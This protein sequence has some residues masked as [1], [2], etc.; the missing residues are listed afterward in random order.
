MKN[1]GAYEVKDPEI[2]EK[3]VDLVTKD[4]KKPAVNFVGK[5]AILPIVR[6]PNVDE[7][8]DFAVEVE[9]GNRHTAMMHSK[10]VDK[11]TK[12][13]KEI[14]TTIFVKNGPSYAGIGVGGM[15]YTT[16]TIAGPTGEGL[17]SAK[18]F[19]RKRR[20]VLQDGLHIRMK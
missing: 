19:C 1:N 14:E 13:A 17:T 12:M 8:I 10:N 11:L 7:A 5:S 9:H 15:G 4:R 16:F 6:V 3:M 20:C 2:I 18:S